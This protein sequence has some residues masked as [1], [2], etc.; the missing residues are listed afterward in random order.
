MFVNTSGII[1]ITASKLGYRPGVVEVSIWGRLAPVIAVVASSMLS[2]MLVA[3]AGYAIFLLPKRIIVSASSLKT[4]LELDLLNKYKTLY[5]TERVYNSIPDL[6][7]G[8]IKTVKLTPPEEDEANKI[9]EEYGITIEDAETITLGK[10][11]HAK[12]IIIPNMPDELKTKYKI[13]EN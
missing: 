1:N 5:V 12:K 7:A 10:K 13:T 2:L 8:K 4:L 6:P 9:A 11:L 3:S